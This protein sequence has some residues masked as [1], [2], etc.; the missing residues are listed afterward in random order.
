MAAAAAAAADL[1]WLLAVRRACRLVRRAARVS[2]ACCA[3]SQRWC[4][5][6]CAAVFKAVP[7]AVIDDAKST[8][9]MGV[10]VGESVGE[11]VA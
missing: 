9:L 10:G 4:V 5:R 7:S 3:R 8:A 11:G 2:R 6:A 1:A